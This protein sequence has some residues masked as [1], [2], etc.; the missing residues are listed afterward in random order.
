MVRSSRNRINAIRSFR[1]GSLAH[2]SS[3]TA[4]GSLGF[5]CAL[6]DVL[7]I[8]GPPLRAEGPSLLAEGHRDGPLVGQLSL[9]VKELRELTAMM[10]G[11]QSVLDLANLP[12]N[13]F[14]L[15][16]A[17][18]IFSEWVDI[19][20]AE[21]RKQPSPLPLPTL[22]VVDLV[23]AL[24]ARPSNSEGRGDHQLRSWLAYRRGGC[25]AADWDH[26]A[27]KGELELIRKMRNRLNHAPGQVDLAAVRGLL[28][29]V[30]R[31]YAALGN[32]GPGTTA[33]WNQILDS[34][35]SGSLAHGVLAVCVL[36]DPQSVGICCSK[37]KEQL[38]GRRDLIDKL[39]GDVRG[40]LQP[41]WPSRWRVALTRHGQVG[42]GPGS[43]L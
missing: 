13:L 23:H 29:G 26:A 21:I 22:E 31:V 16:A 34:S 17:A 18:H 10:V 1:N 20:G 40:A 42:A 11:D 41:G 7:L 5:V 37:S 32:L 24:S 36:R 30:S 33:A 19:F 2:G 28:G 35:S 27:M 14:A 12:G 6:R 9:I 3:P 38:V 4:S 25:S 15:V 43:V 8:H 39:A